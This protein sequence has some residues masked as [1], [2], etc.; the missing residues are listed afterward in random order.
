METVAET[1]FTF[2]AVGAAIVLAAMATALLLGHYVFRLSTDDLFGI[3]SGVTGN[4]AILVH[5]N[6]T[7]PSERIDVAF[8]TI[9]PYEP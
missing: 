7:I 3:A 2:L 9:F 1:G 5:A 6:R 8:A 4:P